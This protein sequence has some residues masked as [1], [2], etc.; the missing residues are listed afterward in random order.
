VPYFYATR[1]EGDL[2]VIAG[3]DARHLAGPLR[4]RVGERI[5]VVDPAG[6]L[7]SVRLS[8]VSSREVAGTVV[9]TQP[10]DPEPRAKVTV[11]IS[12]LPAQ[13]L[14][15]TLSRCTELGAASF[16]L[17]AAE[18]SVSRAVKPD[19]WAAIC[20][21]AAMLAGRLRIPSVSG[22]VPLREAL[23]EDGLMLDRSGESRLID[24]IK[25]D[26]TLLI[27]PE[28]GWSP[29]ELELGAGRLVTM[30]PRNLRADT[31]AIAALGVIVVSGTGTAHGSGP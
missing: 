5:S 22:P 9:E 28:G 6:F 16:L 19:R 1:R 7:L 25:G 14:E 21:E 2:V 12:L 30:G 17:I 10:H 31:A 29:A 27:G 24:R 8:S 23:S 11:G 20:R 18:R 15:Y 26:C 13:Q 4:A 3:A